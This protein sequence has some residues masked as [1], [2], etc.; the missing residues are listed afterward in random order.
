MN[1]ARRTIELLICSACGSEARR[2]N[3]K[4]CLTC[5]KLLRE[6]YQ[7]LDALR[8]S[9]R[10]QGKTF[11][12][13]QPKRE[14]VENLFERNDNS[15]SETAWAC[16]VYSFVPYLGILFVPLA[17]LIGSF[18]VFVSYRKP[19]VGGRKL[20]LVSVGLSFVVLIVQIFLWWLLY[21]IPEIGKQM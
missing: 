7:P 6:D 19:R 5:G 3:A 8:A 4:F 1:E 2:G 16:V 20:S 13:D 14:E 9:Y 21:I 10:M 11:S 18:G 17:L 15:V 12:L